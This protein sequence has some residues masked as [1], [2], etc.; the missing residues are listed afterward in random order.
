METKTYSKVLLGNQSKIF[1]KKTQNVKIVAK[2]EFF[3]V[4]MI[5][6]LKYQTNERKTLK[7]N[8]EKNYKNGKILLNIPK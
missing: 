1:K 8:T 3:V 5:I 7:K 4:P 6:K 2:K